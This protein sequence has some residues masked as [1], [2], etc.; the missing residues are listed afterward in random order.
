MTDVCVASTLTKVGYAAAAFPKGAQ[1][2]ALLEQLWTKIKEQLSDGLTTDL[3]QSAQRHAIT[4]GEMQKS[5]VLGLAMSWSQALAV[6]GR[7][8]PQQ[9]LNAIQSVTEKEVA[10]VA[11]KYLDPLRAVRAV[12]TPKPSGS[13]LTANSL[14]R[15][16]SFERQPTK[17]V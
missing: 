4:A 8:S 9:D 15:M 12:L 16:E 11:K 13:P 5:S 1:G 3:V 7:Q 14:P 17:G 2:D 6:E 10:A